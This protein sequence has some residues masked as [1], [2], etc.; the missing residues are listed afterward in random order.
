[1]PLL[2]PGN[3]VKAGATGNAGYMETLVTKSC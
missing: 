3:K 2:M 1:M